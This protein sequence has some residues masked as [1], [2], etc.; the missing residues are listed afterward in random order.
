M[1]LCL[2][3]DHII[4]LLD[5]HLRETHAHVYYDTYIKMFTIAKKLTQ[6]PTSVEWINSGIFMPQNSIQQ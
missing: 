3:Y 5:I 4:S 1:K 6:T 2:F